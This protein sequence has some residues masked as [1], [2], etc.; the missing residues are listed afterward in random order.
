MDRGAGEMYEYDSE[1]T[2][3]GTVG[4]VVVVLVRWAV[5]FA[6]PGPVAGNGMSSGWRTGDSSGGDS[7]AGFRTGAA[8]RGVAVPAE[9]IRDETVKNAPPCADMVL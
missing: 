6:P 4:A 5:S 8:S 3:G 7:S 2:N 1:C 9:Q